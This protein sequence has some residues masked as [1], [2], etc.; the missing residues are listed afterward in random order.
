[1]K[2]IL[3]LI[4]LTTSFAVAADNDSYLTFKAEL[5]EAITSKNLKLL[6]QLFYT[7]GASEYQID[8]IIHSYEFNWE[9]YIFDKIELKPIN[10]PSY[11]EATIQA[12]LGGKIM[13]GHTYV[14]NMTPAKICSIRF[15][16]KEGKSSTGIFSPIGV[17]PDG[18]VKFVLL[19][20]V[21]EQPRP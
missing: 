19:E 18:A 10:D 15:K 1:M 7:K 12:M 14:P 20:K 3:A 11:S 21:Q 16:S 13:N 6:N 8:T 4:L 9:N 2:I 17:A 5:E